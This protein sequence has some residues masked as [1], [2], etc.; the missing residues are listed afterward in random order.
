MRK[1]IK[2]MVRIKRKSYSHANPPPIDNL[3]VEVISARSVGYT[4]SATFRTVRTFSTGPTNREVDR[5]WF[6]RL[7]GNKMIIHNAGMFT[8]AGSTPRKM[9][10]SK[11]S[12][13]PLNS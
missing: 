12:W 5:L 4:T 9:R 6:L 7:L 3:I 1:K 11:L 13:T 2:M 10:P 8:A